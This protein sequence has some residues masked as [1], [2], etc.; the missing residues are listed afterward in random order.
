MNGKPLVVGKG[1]VGSA[2]FEI[3]RGVYPDAEWLDI[4]PKQIQ[5]KISVMHICFPYSHKFVEQTCSYIEKFKP[6]LTLI[7][8]TIPPYTTFKIYEMLHAPICHSPVRGNVKDGLKWSFFTYTKF[9]GPV[10]L[11][12]GQQAA[13]YYKT[14]SFRTYLCNSPLETEFAKLISTT[15][16]GLL[17]AWF[18][19]IERI[20]KHFN[21]DYNNV[22]EFFRLDTIE[23]GGK[24]VRPIFTPDFIG[25][26]CVIP[27][28]VMLNK[29]FRSKFISALLDSNKRKGLAQ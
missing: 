15:Y 8:S 16:Y 22:V 1:E 26:H 12:Y 3:I 4:K 25:G 23:S 20:C 9:I 24:H 19:E 5:G 10:K 21:L 11:E 6:A 28:A 14:L 13:N 18:Q 17:I 27:N 7:E 2:L 29:I